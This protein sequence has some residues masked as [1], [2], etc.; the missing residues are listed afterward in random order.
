MKRCQVCGELKSI[1]DFYRAA[2]MRD[3]YRNDCKLCNLAA[4]KRRYEADPKLAIARV[5]KWQQE[6]AD[7]LNAYRRAHNARP[8]RKRALRDGYYRR[9]F[10][11]SAADVDSMLLAQNGVCAICG[12]APT[13]AQGWHVDHD[14]E[15]GRIRGV[16]CQ[17]CNHAI[18]LLDEDPDRLRAAADYL[19]GA[20]R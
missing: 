15:T 20:T 8:E 2:G 5:K 13:R 17:R 9:N 18:G 10:G 14:H 6:N 4:K 12:G 16:L 11:I 3:G 19:E 7:R 1:E